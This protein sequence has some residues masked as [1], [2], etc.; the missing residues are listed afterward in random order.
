[1]HLVTYCSIYNTLTLLK[2]FRI[3]L[4]EIL[5]LNMTNIAAKLFQKKTV[6]YLFSKKFS[7]IEFHC[8]MAI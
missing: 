6:R 4:K 5:E 1:M 3:D 7:I 2:G 8:T